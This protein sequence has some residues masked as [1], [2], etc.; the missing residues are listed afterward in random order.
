MPSAD[1]VL[2]LRCQEDDGE[3]FDEI[4]AHYKDGIYN[5]IWR[6]ISNLDDVEDLTQEVFVRAF[7]SIK[8]FRGE[9]NLRTWLYKIATNLCVDK[10]RRAG[11]EKRLLIPLDRESGDDEPSGFEVPDGTYDPER[12][13][14][15]SELQIEVQKALS[16][17]PEKLRAAILLCD[18][19]GMTYEDIAGAI[20]CPL[21]TVKSRLFNA[22]LRLRDLLKPYVQAS[23][24]PDDK[25]RS[26]DG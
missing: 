11:L 2:V 1:T 12:A 17:L 25:A 8:S 7:T 19:E 15:R 16:R 22:R 3:A 4:V 26:K 20:G 14:E 9:S 6:M 13:Y 18:I 10:Y 5:Y 24:T 21:G 23:W